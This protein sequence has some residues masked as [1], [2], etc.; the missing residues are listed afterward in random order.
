MVVAVH[1]AGYACD[2]LALEQLSKIYGFRII[3]DAAHALG[4]QHGYFQIGGCNQSEAA[5]FSFHPVKSITTGEGGAIL[6]N[7]AGL[8][9]KARILRHHG[10]VRDVA[11]L[12]DSNLPAYHYEQQDLGFNFRL[13]DIHAALGLS[14][15]AK[16]SRFIKSRQRIARAY[17]QRLIDEPSIRLPLNQMNPLGISILFIFQRH[18]HEIK[19]TLI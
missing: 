2:M 14:Q 13:S 17:Y 3:E 5:C 16:L 7:N 10:I 11:M 18:R 12:Y 6:T 19:L 9:I 4:A 1:M 8:A 15:L